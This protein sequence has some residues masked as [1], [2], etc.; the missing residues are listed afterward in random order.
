MAVEFNLQVALQQESYAKKC[1]QMYC[2]GEMEISDED[3]Q[4]LQDQ[5][6][7]KMDNWKPEEVGDQNEYEIEDEDG[8][9]GG[10]KGNGENLR[11]ATTGAAGVAL[12]STFLNPIG[13]ILACF[14]AFAEG[15][16]YTIQGPNKAEH[17]ELMNLKDIML[18]EQSVIEDES[19][20][21]EVTQEEIDAVLEEY[22]HNKD[23]IMA[24][25]K[26]KTEEMNELEKEREA[27]QQNAESDEGLDEAGQSRLAELNEQIGA[28]GH[29]IDVL[30]A[31][32]VGLTEETND[33]VESGEGELGEAFEITED[34]KDAA[35]LAA[36]FDEETRANAEDEAKLQAANAILGAG[37]AAVVAIQ[38]P[39]N[40]FAVSA[41]IAG[42][43]G[44]VMSTI[45][46]VEQSSIVEDI[47]VEIDLRNVIMDQ[48]ENLNGDADKG[49]ANADAG[50]ENV[51]VDD[52][53]LPPEPEMTPTPN[54]DPEPDPEEEEKKEEDK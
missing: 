6:K 8:E 42:A 36:T 46:A 28:L 25:I 21:I 12:L 47:G 13:A 11:A 27:L 2:N 39:I 48:V 43:S 5:Y 34:A 35:E 32:L 50:L 19:E 10:A 4:A 22:E 53:E 38:A 30:N 1:Y 45:G 17:E 7:G 37:A 18:G 3:L 26:D 23:A 16:M 51:T 40:P 29:E 24:A 9:E 52:V 54:V 44:A 49:I 41:A 20:I 15:L 31:A 14:A 33:E